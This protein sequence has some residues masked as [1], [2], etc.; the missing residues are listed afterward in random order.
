MCVCVTY[1][2]SVRAA[3]QKDGAVEPTITRMSKELFSIIYDD[4]V[5]IIRQMNIILFVSF[6]VC[7][8]TRRKH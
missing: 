6:F 7:F 4:K 2:V 8:F 1:S 3:L 5:K